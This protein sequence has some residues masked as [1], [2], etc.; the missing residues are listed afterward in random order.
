MLHYP[1]ITEKTFL[2]QSRAAFDFVNGSKVKLSK[3][4]QALC[5][6][7][8]LKNEH[9]LP[10]LFTQSPSVSDVPSNVKPLPSDRVHEFMTIVEGGTD[11]LDDEISIYK[12][13]IFNLAE[14]LTAVDVVDAM[15]SAFDLDDDTT[16]MNSLEMAQQFIDENKTES[17]ASEAA[18]LQSCKRCANKLSCG[19]YCLNETCPHSDF[20]QGVDIEELD[21]ISLDDYNDKHGTNFKKRLSVMCEFHDDRDGS[22]Y[23]FDASE[24]FYNLV[25]YGDG[26]LRAAI[27]GI[28]D[29]G[30]NCGMHTDAI[31]YWF[32]MNK[33]ESEVG[34]LMKSI[35]GFSVW[36]EDE[37]ALLA[38]LNVYN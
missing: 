10:S 35:K 12:N 32:E 34:C 2:A 15:A 23:I 37:N 5:I 13:L 20:P 14:K 25:R 27:T 21:V 28:I 38:F 9:L 36:V 3:V 16:I 17:H 19:G 29:E 33:P 30:L 1:N 26:D 31:A 18:Y 8:N 11:G 24:Y 7:L 6:Q 4:R 22:Q